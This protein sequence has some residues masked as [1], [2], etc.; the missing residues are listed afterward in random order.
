[1]P[2]ATVFLSPSTRAHGSSLSTDSFFLLPHPSGSKQVEDGKVE[3]ED[4]LHTPAGSY[5][6]ILGN[7]GSPGPSFST[8]LVGCPL[9]LLHLL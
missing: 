8:L 1:M 6:G 3:A 7:L 5:C 4:G 2:R 9:S